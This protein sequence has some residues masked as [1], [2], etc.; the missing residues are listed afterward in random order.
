MPKLK[1]SPT[2]A[3]SRKS[4]AGNVQE[5]QIPKDSIYNEQWDLDLD[6]IR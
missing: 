2:D 4:V 6:S 5:G 1:L 3:G